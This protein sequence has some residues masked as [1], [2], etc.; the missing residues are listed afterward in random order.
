MNRKRFQSILTSFVVL[1]MI[2]TIAWSIR[3]NIVNGQS[4]RWYVWMKTSPCSGRTDWVSVA[5]ENPSG[6]GN[7]FQQ[8]PG[9]H[10]WPTFAEAMAEADSLR[11][12]PMFSSYCCREYSVWK[13]N[14]TGKLSVVVGKFG[15]AGF[16]WNKIS[17]DLC[18]EEAFAQ[19]G[20]PAACSQMH[21][22][23][24]T[25]LN[26]KNLTFYQRPTVDQCEADCDANAQC[27]GFTWI[28]AGTYNRT[29]PAM[30]YLIA[31]VT[32]S[33]SARG[34]ISGIKGGTTT[35]QPPVQP[36]GDDLSGTWT[37][38]YQE[39]FSG[40][41][42]RFQMALSRVAGGKWQGP[43]D[44]NNL[45]NPSTSFKT[46]ATV[47][48]TGSGRLRL[49]YNAPDGPQQSDGTYTRTQI[50]FGDSASHVTYTKQ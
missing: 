44:Y 37:A 22:E 42:F 19:A 38:N 28:Q 16:G 3:P 2:A 39:P 29:D 20:L 5:K 10:S 12:S 17:S 45:D 48:V 24:N 27:K 1:L 25:A 50:T 40:Q 47:Q 6:G 41:H 7:A 15:T 43:L 31:Q 8:F 23:Q 11:T 18:C 32:G 13:N 35:T 21:R 36:S 4:E 33:T 34:H 30:C 26:G 14:E 49:T 46:Q 9:S